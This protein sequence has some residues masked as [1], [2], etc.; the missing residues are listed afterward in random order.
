MDNSPHK[1]PDSKNPKIYDMPLQELQKPR[2]EPL[3]HTHVISV[4]SI[5]LSVKESSNININQTQESAFLVLDHY[6]C[7]IVIFT[8]IYRY[9]KADSI[10]L[11]LL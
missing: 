6:E 2:M 9:S 1:H 7:R 4:S 8:R 10:M 5:V 11:E 3:K